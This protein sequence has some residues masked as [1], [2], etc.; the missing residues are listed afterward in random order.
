MGYIINKISLYKK[1]IDKD[2]FRYSKCCRNMS[3][4]KNRFF[5]E[6]NDAALFDDIINSITEMSSAHSSLFEVCIVAKNGST[7]QCTDF[8]VSRFIRTV[9]VDDNSDNY[10][11][12]LAT[13]EFIVSDG[14]LPEFF[15]KRTGQKYFKICGIKSEENNGIDIRKNIGD[16]AGIQHNVVQADILAFSSQFSK[17]NV[18]KVCKIEHIF[19]GKVVVCDYN[20]F[21]K[22]FFLG[23]N[24]NVFIKD[25]S[26]NRKRELRLIDAR[27][28]KEPALLE[29]IYEMANPVNDIIWY[30]KKH[31]T[32]VMSTHM[33]DNH[34]DKC[35]YVFTTGKSHRTYFEDFGSRYSRRVRKVLNKRDIKRLFGE[36]NIN[37][38]VLIK[39]LICIGDVKKISTKRNQTQIEV[40][41][42]PNYDLSK[43]D[44][45]VLALRDEGNRIEHCIDFSFCGRKLELNINIENINLEGVIWD[46]K[47][48]YDGCREK[49]ALAL[50][51]PGKIEKQLETTLKRNQ[52]GDSIFF[53]YRSKYRRLAF[54]HREL[55]R[56]DGYSVRIKELLA[57]IIFRLAKPCFRRKKIW[58]V[59]EKFC[60]TAQDNGFYFFKFCMEQLS[61]NDKKNIYYV[62]QSDSDERSNVEQYG[63]NVID[64]M[65]LKHMI[66][67]QAAA[68]VIGSD[69]K[70]HLYNWRSLPSCMST[71]LRKK[72]IFFLQHG[73]L[74]LK[75]VDSIFGKHGS[76]PMTYFT[77]SSDYEQRIVMENFGYSAQD[78]PAVGLARWDVLEDESTEENK[79]ILVMPTWRSWLE[80][81][82]ADTFK[83]SD[84][85][86]NYM[87][88]FTN[89]KLEQIL[90]KYD[91][92]MVFYIHPKFRDYLG[93]FVVD[94][95]RIELIPFG[96]RPLNEIIRECRMLITD[97]SSVC[98]DVYYLG[99]PVMFYQFDYDMYM[100]IHGSYMDMTTELFGD[101]F[102]NSDEV[103]KGIEENLKNNF[104]ESNRAASMRKDYFK[105]IDNN[106]SKRTYEYLKEKGF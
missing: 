6:L 42:Y 106:N 66:Y 51:A 53:P 38:T 45:I 23:L 89:P 96:S 24:E 25:Y 64:F 41:A 9:V 61:D 19:T 8:A 29:R 50:Y 43:I 100:D 77:T 98:W 14:L 69:A 59:F 81:R 1:G 26:Y 52:I 15:I 47:V 17:D 90:E 57:Y 12:M 62:I 48:Y 11:E 86:E 73:V 78:A 40:S 71:V 18:V 21:G 56:Y 88:L 95:N 58:L 92:R 46:I 34:M 33:F 13:A 55:S 5:I 60:S 70:S 79:L 27:I 75:R 31:F 44:K 37:K 80:G 35:S 65:S 84:Y 7:W 102:F 20:L 99:K 3:I 68:I 87:K 30:S 39:Q 76:N 103:I 74:A 94:S 91:G 16:I 105:Y 28:A 101:R 2:M 104:R 93:N 82:T 49:Q 36:L 72:K 83:A 63:K 54:M 32:G 97:Y 67:I 10:P 22:V 85:Y 4:V